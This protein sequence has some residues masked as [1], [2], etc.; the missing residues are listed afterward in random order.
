[1]MLI[2]GTV[3]NKDLPVIIGEVKREGDFLIIDG[4]Q[5][6]RTQGTGAMIS[7][8]LA[9]TDYMKKNPPHAILVGD[10]GD[11]KGTRAMFKYLSEN[12]ASIKPDLLALHYC[13][14]I[15]ALVKQLLEAI[16]KSGHR[17]YLLAD[18]GGMYAAKGAGLAE[19]FDAFTPDLSEIA[20]LADPLATHPAYVSRHLFEWD[21]SQIPKMIDAAYT[22]H[23]APK[24]LLVKG[25]TDYVAYDGKIVATINEPNVPMLEPIGGTGDTITGTTSALIYCGFPPKEAAIMACKINRLAGEA[26]LVTPAT[27]VRVF[28][29]HF[30]DV[31]HLVV[32]N[33]VTTGS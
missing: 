25:A 24:L 27:K 15:M 19:Q 31:L 32:P 29:D 11:G 8:A 12:I 33:S 13:L 6:A 28:I 10:P 9:V 23:S 2:L 21:S 14:P 20:F 16:N 4:H 17:P 26:A 22:N 1:M 3:P 30:K 7:A 5:I 18:A